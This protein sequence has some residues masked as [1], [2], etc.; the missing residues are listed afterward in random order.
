[1]NSTSRYALLA[2]LGLALVAVAPAAP[3]FAQDQA[4]PV[5]KKKAREEEKARKKA[6]AEAAKA[7]QLKLSPAVANA[8]NPAVAAINKKDA[9]GAEAA[10][11]KARTVAT[12]PDEKYQIAQFALNAAQISGDQAKLSAALDE[13]ISTGEASGRF[14]QEDRARYYP[15]QGQFAYQAQ[16]FPKAVEAMNKAVAAGSKD[17]NVYVIIADSQSRNG[18][19]AEAGASIQKAIDAER[20]AGKVPPES[21]FE[22]GSRAAATAAQTETFVKVSTQWLAAYPS[23]KVWANVLNNYRAVGKLNQQ[24][25]V[26]L[27]RMARA[28]GAIAMMPAREYNDLLL[29]VYRA[30]PAEAV[31]VIQEGVAAKKLSMSDRDAKELLPIS[32][33][34]VAQEKK[35]LE[36]DTKAAAAPAAKFNQAMSMGDVWYGYKDYARAAELYKVA[37]TK[38]G[39]DANLANLRLGAALAQGGDKAGAL[40]A[41]NNVTTRPLADLAAFWK[42]WVQH[43]AA[44]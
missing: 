7:A 37:L 18:Q 40:A 12:T 4:A 21:W 27:L 16:N 39:V 30:Y 2:A 33:G 9:A 29:G 10:I 44:S 38:P 1:M 41:L 26:D 36:A 3:G 31:A 24:V 6:E 14:T 5:D 25:D 32:E 15:F 8:L 20:A 28:S 42:V 17:S 43:P 35:T 13:V 11:A 34:K 23:K 19:T 22:L